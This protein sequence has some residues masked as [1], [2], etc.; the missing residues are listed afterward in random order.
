MEISEKQIFK[1]KMFVQGNNNTQKRR[2]GQGFRNSKGSYTDDRNAVDSVLTDKLAE[3]RSLPFLAISCSYCMKLHI[4]R[5][6]MKVS[7]IRYCRLFARQVSHNR[8]KS[9]MFAIIKPNRIRGSRKRAAHLSHK[10]RCPPK[11]EHQET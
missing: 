3:V 8:T 6:S 10:L 7:S 5:S 9:I 11:K 4:S 2:P 1:L